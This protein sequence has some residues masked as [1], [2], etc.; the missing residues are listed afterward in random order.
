M[1]QQELLIAVLTVLNESQ[2]N[3]MV[4]GSIVSSIQGE[5]RLTH[6]ID[7][8]LTITKHEVPKLIKAFPPPRFYLDQDAANSAST[9]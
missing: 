1:L 8:L 4:T 7:I 3:Y 2:I 6:D 9:C 5:P